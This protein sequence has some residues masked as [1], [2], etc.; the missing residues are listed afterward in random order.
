MAAGA[1]EYVL[2]VDEILAHAEVAAQNIICELPRLVYPKDERVLE[3]KLEAVMDLGI[4]KV[5]AENI[6][7]LKLAV[8][9]GLRIYG[10]A[11]LNVINSEALQK[12]ADMG[13]YD[14]TLSYECN[15]R[16]I[17]ELKGDVKR[18]VI[19]YGYQ[20]LMHFRAC[21]LSAGNCKDCGGEG[22]LTDRKGV[23]FRVACENRRYSVMYNSVPLYVLDKLPKNADGYTLY[24]TSESAAEAKDIVKKY[25]AGAPAEGEFTRG[26][27]Y[28][29][30]L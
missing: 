26:L 6:G 5:M 14:I 21:P 20:P 1:D 11:G 17:A 18:N 25:K 3:E 8:K 30:L 22:T 24:F 13:V 28:K 4:D 19:V 16:D 2:P 12:Y 15:A 27:Y 7:S 10:G 29:E 9:K 23:D